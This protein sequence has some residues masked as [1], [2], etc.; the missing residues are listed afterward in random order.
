[1]DAGVWRTK[2]TG[3]LLVYLEGQESPDNLVMRALKD[4][5]DKRATKD[6]R[7]AKDQEDLKATGGK[8]DFLDFL[9]SMRC[10]VCRVM[11][12]QEDLLAQTAATEQKENLEYR[13]HHMVGLVNQ[14]LQDI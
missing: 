5:L 6:F 9:E 14:V 13:H 10:R 3:V 1:M 2:A 12:D 8:W 7:A 4:F 11:L